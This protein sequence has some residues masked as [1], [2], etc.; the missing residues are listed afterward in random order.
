MAVRIFLSSG[1][2]RVVE[3]ADSARLDGSFFVINRWYPNLNRLE[4][5]LT[6]RADES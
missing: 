2:Q 4:T 5:V 1:A 3:A 6:L